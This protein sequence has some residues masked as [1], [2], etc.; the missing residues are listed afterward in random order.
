MGLV[1]KWYWVGWCVLGKWS[2]MGLG[3]V[4]DW[5]GFGLGLVCDWCL[6]QAEL[7]RGCPGWSRGFGGV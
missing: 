7:V 2:E 1:W 5:F 6:I 3:L 4:W